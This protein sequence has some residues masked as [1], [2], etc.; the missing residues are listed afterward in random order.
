MPQIILSV[1][2]T[3]SRLKVQETL[4]HVLASRLH[5][6]AVVSEVHRRLVVD[7]LAE[8]DVL[9]MG[10]DRPASVGEC[11]GIGVQHRPQGQGWMLLPGDVG[12]MPEGLLTTVAQALREHAVVHG[13]WKGRRCYPV[14]IS[15]DLYGEAVKVNGPERLQRLMARYPSHVVPL[16]AVERSG[17]ALSTLGPSS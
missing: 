8:R 17:F 10:G 1:L 6:C 2:P 5:V 15:A 7:T 4:A 16:D 14:G 11:L 12:A 3:M 13:L 9:A